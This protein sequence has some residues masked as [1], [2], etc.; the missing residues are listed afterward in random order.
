MAL[1]RDKTK[2]RRGLVKPD[3]PSTTVPARK[4]PSQANSAMPL[5]SDA[6]VAALLS[7]RK[8]V[9]HSPEPL[10]GGAS[11]PALAID[12]DRGDGGRKLK[13][14]RL[15]WKDVEG[16]VGL[17]FA[18]KEAKMQQLALLH[19][20]QGPEGVGKTKGF[21]RWKKGGTDARR[22]AAGRTYATYKC[23][24]F[25]EARCPFCL[26]VV[27]LDGVF[28]IQEGG[29]PH[30][31][32]SQ[33]VGDKKVGAPKFLLQGVS[34][35]TITGKY[36]AEVATFLRGRDPVRAQIFDDAN[37]SGG[38]VEGSSPLGVVHQIR[39]FRKRLMRATARP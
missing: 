29:Y 27:E 18:Q 15:P 10:R 38:G 32:H 26:R 14:V 16:G 31:D 21:H 33:R 28:T 5:A 6:A 17:T 9:A 20:G 2:R 23:A 13:R 7:L 19:F 11:E 4:G 8:R 12:S 35:S 39:S 3:A 22:N 30:A 36:P 25:T 34:S 1:S 24:Y 37:A